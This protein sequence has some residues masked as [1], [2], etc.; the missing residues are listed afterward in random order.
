MNNNRNKRNTNLLQTKAFKNRFTIG[1]VIQ[2]VVALVF[3]IFVFRF[4]YLGVT[5]KID[6]EDISERTKLLYATN[7]TISASRGTIYDRNG[8]VVAEDSHLYTVYAI[9]D[10]SYIDYEGKAAYVTNKE[11][12]AA[13]LSTVL[14]ISQDKIFKYLN[15]STESFQ[16]QFGSAGSNLTLA[17]KKAIEKM[18]LPGIKF[19]QTPS[20]IYPN[21]IFASHIVGLATPTYDKKTG[22]EVLTGTMG[23][24]AWFNKDLTGTDGYQM[25]N[26]ASKNKRNNI[27]K[28]AQNGN[29][30]Y[31]TIDS[32][33]Q[34][35]LEQYM[36]QVMTKYRPVKLTGVV[37]NIKTGEV[38][39][40]SQRPTF[41]PQTKS[42]LTGSYRDVLVQDTYEPGSVF[43]ILTLSAAVN[44]GNY[45]PNSYYNSG[46]VT[47]AGSTIHDWQTSGWG[48]IPFSQAFPRSSNVGFTL[49][50][51]KM[52]KKVW[53]S[54][55]NKF[56]IGKKTGVTL[57]GEQAGF[58]QF[59][60]VVDAA[61]TS[62]GQ[63][64]NVNVMQMM[65]AFS[66]LAND[67]QMVKP[68]FISKEVNANG[69]VVK[70]YKVKKV[71]SPVYSAETAKT[72]LSNM[73][74]VLN[75]NY[76]TGY[77]YRIPGV[78]IGVKTGTAQI[79]NP[80]GGGYLTGDSNYIFS[81]VGVYPANKPKYAVYI[82]MQQPRN[83]SDPA[84]TILSQIF[85]PVMKQVAVMD[86]NNTSSID[87]RQ[88]PNIVGL[89]TEEAK[90]SVK[91]S[92]LHLLVLGTGKKVKAQQQESGHNLPSGTTVM[93]YTG[94]KLKMPD[95][96]GWNS[97]L[98]EE[99][100]ELTGIRISQSGNGKVE[101]QS[102]QIGKEINRSSKIKL[103]L[104]E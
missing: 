25:T 40:A 65:Q 82:T 26:S 12:T 14:K 78:S 60:S 68:Q 64:V 99:F 47:V 3:V 73:K 27:Y 84:E 11:E 90:K 104:K 21:G 100:S 79:A 62:F 44:S 24:E 98:I 89:S 94:G 59:S 101:S 53:K 96:T 58:M 9:L 1:R 34:S 80:K 103:K 31:L 2:I 83:M 49:L 43:K 76:G 8:L 66:S 51:Q 39:A 7:R 46:S 16:V 50:E 85:K 72:V 5:Q 97:T 29:N 20:R 28:A 57:P 61:T 23:L 33:I 38:L 6:G 4:L 45:H 87:L 54:Y 15:P 63:G 18:N 70:T 81:V 41:N 36:T 10:K 13:K 92:G 91:E 56:R 55:L 42:G 75:K 86:R 17:Q 74:R 95:M 67:G 71:G 19:Y 37:E 69:K 35:L 102:I 77:A 93:A 88:V 52:G 22:K 32:Q 48:S 30:L